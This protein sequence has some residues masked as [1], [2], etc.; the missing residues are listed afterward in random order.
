MLVDDDRD[1]YVLTRELFAELAGAYSLDW[2]SDYDTGLRELASGAHDVYLLD[3]RL[4]SRDGLELL[5]EG[6]RAG[7]KAPIII[8]TG[9]ADRELDFAAMQA[10]AADYLIKGK[11]DASGLERA[12]RYA[13]QQKRN[14]IELEARVKERTRELAQVNVTLRRWSEQLQELAK[15]AAHLSTAHDFSSVI[16]FVTQSAREIIGAHA[17]VTRLVTDAPGHSAGLS[18]SWSNKYPVWRAAQTRFGNTALDQLVCGVN[19]PQR[20]EQRALESLT[21]ARPEADSGTLP[22]MRGWLAAP[23]IGRDGRNLGLVQLSDKYEGEFTDADEA[24][25]VQLAQTASIALE[26]AR[27]Y[28]DLRERDR[29]KDEFLAMLAHELRNPLA[30]IRNAVQILE[31][32]AARDAHVGAARD[33]IGRQVNHLVRLV[34]DLLDVS[35]ITRGKINLVKEPVEISNVIAVAV[36]SCRPIIDERRHQLELLL[37]SQSVQVKADLTRL[38]QVVLNL[39]NNAA[40]YTDEGGKI[41]LSVA[42]EGKQVVIRVRDNGTGIAPEMLPTIFDVFT[43]VDRTLDRS[44]GGLGLGLTLVRRLTEMHGGQVEAHSAGPGQGSEFVV[45]LA[46]LTE[47]SRDD[48]KQADGRSPARPANGACRRILIVDDN[49]DSAE[50]LA[51]LLR[52]RGH[53]V[54][55]AYDGRQGLAVAED[56]RPRVVIL[57]I[58]L[59]GLDGYGVA[60]ALRANPLFREV[61]L[62]ALTGYGAEEDRRAC[63]RAGFD[64]HLVKPVDLAPLFGLL[65]SATPNPGVEAME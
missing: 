3:Y 30:P 19:R 45:R 37:P 5:R 35:R 64:A 14:E 16:G 39:L 24:L 20:L 60:R 31:L 13:L 54:R 59:P 17:A 10:G 65:E 4:G 40:K 61:L 18:V 46:L 29:R 42:V 38:A 8:M 63:Y 33:L 2:V 49:R 62:V 6:L 48:V 44:Q 27:L 7:C 11:I 1:D 28:Q 34:D 56:F 50:S 57:D 32:P 26:N 23:L 36:E 21:E 9:Q 41:G 51:M 43:Q 52:V 53:D 22:P 55:T 12:L 15:L 25:L 58:G 47:E